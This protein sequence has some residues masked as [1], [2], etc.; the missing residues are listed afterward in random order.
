MKTVAI[1]NI[2]GI[3]AVVFYAFT[4]LPS[5]LRVV[6]PKTKSYKLTRLLL[7][8]R[9]T[10][11]L[12]AFLLAFGHVYLVTMQRR[13]DFLDP[14]T[15]ITYFHGSVTFVVFLVL[16]ATSNNWS[17]K[18]LKPANWKALHQL[19]YVAFVFL[20][21][22]IILAMVGKWTPLTGMGVAIFTLLIPLVVVRHWREWQNKVSKVNRKIEV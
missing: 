14:Y 22:H 6:F 19:T 4:L 11:G 9:R 3:C 8:Y 2:T 20:A 10:T 18:R 21:V 12:L 15:Y 17:I 5:I 1:A 16:A 7:K 13:F